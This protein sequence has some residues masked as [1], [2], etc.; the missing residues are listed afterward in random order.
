M[1][2]K[3]DVYLVDA[4]KNRN[5]WQDFDEAL[6]AGYKYFAYGS[7]GNIEGE[8]I[9]STADR[10]DLRSFRYEELFESITD[11]DHTEIHVRCLGV[12]RILWG[13]LGDVAVDKDERIKERFLHFTEGTLR[14]DVW[15]WFEDTFQASVNDG[16][17]D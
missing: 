9:Y 6:D 14:K 1:I 12:A 3:K 16:N 5:C 10:L 7:N 11:K 2:T 8:Y 4:F 17:F 13:I 15:I